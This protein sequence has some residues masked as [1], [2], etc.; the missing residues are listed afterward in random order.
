[1]KV[2]TEDERL[3]IA[4]CRY[5][6]ISPL[7]SRELPRGAQNSIIRDITSKFHE[8]ENN[9]LITVG[10][11]TIE[12]YLSNYRQGGLEALKPVV[13][14][15]KNSLKAF[16]QAVLDAAIE[17]RM[18]KPQLSADSIIDLLKSRSVL[19]A[20]KICV[21][22]LNRHFRRLYKDIPSLK[23]LPRKRFNLLAVDGVHQLWICD[24]WD[25][26]FLLDSAMNKKRRLRLVAIIDSHT[27]YIIQASFYFNENRPC[28]EDTLLKAILKH[29]V[30][31]RFYCDNA[32]IFQSNHLKRIGAELGFRIQHSQPYKPQGR[33]KIERWFRTVADKF[34]PLL[35]SA[36]ESG[37]V[38][39]LAD[40][41]LF[42]AAWVEERY[43]LRRHGTLKM[44]PVK[45]MEDALNSGSVFSKDIEAGT[46]RE[47]F[48]WREN[49]QVTTLASISIN[50]NRYEVDENLIGKKVE[51]RYNPYNLNHMLVFFE[52][53]FR[54]EAR[55][56][57]MKNFAEKCVQDRQENAYQALDAAMD[58]VIAEHAENIKKKSGISF[59]RAMEAEKDE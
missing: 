59:A 32:K 58:A 20:E 15:E 16:P 38:K 36:I 50:G 43:H 53:L 18:A 39:T 22:T 23:R 13:R 2:L 3:R 1:M 34:E 5:D 19:D 29:G 14:V 8:N 31:E 45:A 27:R 55:P 57:Q 17:V 11:R 48:L 21:S 44:T 37:K 51:V 42:L 28:L 40:I 7:L 54:C 56:Y 9:E 12:R 24:I 26:P 30:P 35:Y 4:L 41:N 10:H 25:G 46:V 52:G 6:I 47:T 49:R 33:G